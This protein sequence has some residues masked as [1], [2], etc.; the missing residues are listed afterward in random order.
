MDCLPVL[1]QAANAAAKA[2]GVARL[3]GAARDLVAAVRHADSATT[4]TRQAA[5]LL[6]SAAPLLKGTAGLA[7][8]RAAGVIDL[9]SRDLGA[10]GA[11]I[12]K[13][14]GAR[15]GAASGTLNRALGGALTAAG[16]GLN[17]QN[18][19]RSVLSS[20][21]TAFADAPASAFL[22][23]IAGDQGQLFRFSLGQAAFDQLR[24]SS[25]YNTPAQE[26]LQRTAA[27][28]AVGRGGSTLTVSGA[29]F[30]A[31]HGS[32]HLDALRA[33]GDRLE[34]VTLTTGYGELLG[35]YYLNS[36]DEEQSHFFKDG[37]PR[38]QTFTLEFGLYGD[39]YQNL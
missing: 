5:G 9:A 6:G 14:A 22:L 19:A 4:L 24:R 8:R 27:L 7:A 33:I 21:G 34:P 30:L 38:K 3:P 18:L 39:D 1:N 13:E 26:R 31:A 20:A 16:A 12:L 2:A 15:L 11:Q 28:Q 10:A 17:A 29:I 25:R 36:L 35:R 23:E 32:G 37:A